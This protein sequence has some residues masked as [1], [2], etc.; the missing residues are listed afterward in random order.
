MICDYPET[1]KPIALYGPRISSEADTS[2]IFE[3]PKYAPTKPPT[4]HTADFT[5]WKALFQMTIQH[6][7]NSTLRLNCTKELKQ[8]EKQFLEKWNQHHIEFHGTTWTDMLF[9]LYSNLVCCDRPDETRMKQGPENLKT[10]YNELVIMGCQHAKKKKWPT[11]EEIQSLF[12][13]VCGFITQ[14]YFM[15][16]ENMSALLEH[17][18]SMDIEEEK[19]QF[20][21]NQQMEEENKQNAKEQAE[22]EEE[23]EFA[24]LY[25]S[26]EA[27][28][29][30]EKNRQLQKIKERLAQNKYKTQAYMDMPERVRLGVEE[31][32]YRDFELLSKS[33]DEDVRKAAGTINDANLGYCFTQSAIPLV[34][35]FV[36]LATRVFYQL[37]LERTLQEAFP[38]MEEEGTITVQAKQ[39]FRHWL[40]Q[41]SSKDRAD[42]FAE[43][44]R[45]T[46]FE[47]QL[48]MGARCT[49]EREGQPIETPPLNVLEQELGYDQAEYLAEIA[50]MNIL[51][52]ASD[53]EHR[54]YHVLALAMFDYILG[55]QSNNIEFMNTYMIL[56]TKFY[57]EYER[58]YKTIENHRPRRPLITFLQHRWMIH[59]KEKWIVCED[60]IQAL[61]LWLFIMQ[62]DYQGETHDRFNVMTQWS[63]GTTLQP[64]YQYFFRPNV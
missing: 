59:N 45:W 54:Q 34:S 37:L 9:V 6:L 38:T 14:H 28:R 42:E 19:K 30:A 40:Y 24:Y 8:L 15:I 55:H 56:P 23:E 47:L 31:L 44:Y 63:L 4:D 58:F 16:Q 27:R 53:P 35:K 46:G 51:E 3:K 39:A 2:S 25:M 20:A 10:L 12:D 7:S 22:Q 5:Q 21:L 62:R 32:Q 17:W 29:L 50:T 61:I 33:K 60:V 43:R 64:F 41:F 52:V 49:L 1:K 48:P 57:K 26:E 13:R 18:I 36:P 11:E